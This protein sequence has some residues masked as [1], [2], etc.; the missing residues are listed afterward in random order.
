MPSYKW[1]ATGD[2]CPQDIA[3]HANCLRTDFDLVSKTS[4]I[5]LSHSATLPSSLQ[6][7]ILTGIEKGIAEARNN[8]YCPKW[9]K[10]DE[11]I[12]RDVMLKNIAAEAPPQARDR[13][14]LDHFNR[15][16]KT[17]NALHTKL[18]PQLSPTAISHQS[19]GAD[20]PTQATSV[21]GLVEPSHGTNTAAE[22]VQASGTTVTSPQDMR[23]KHVMEKKSDDGSSEEEHCKDEESEDD[24]SDDEES[25]AAESEDEE[26]KSQ[27]ANDGQAVTDSQDSQ[28]SEN[29]SDSSED[30]SND[31]SS[32]AQYCSKEAQNL[33]IT[34]HDHGT[35]F[36]ATFNIKIEHQANVILLAGTSPQMLRCKVDLSLR[37]FLQ[38]QTP[39]WPNLTGVS[40]AELQGNGD[41]KVVIDSPTRG[42]LRLFMDLA[43][44]DAEF[45]R[46]LVASPVPK[47]WLTMHN[48]KVSSSRF[49][50]RKEKAAMIKQLAD[51]NHASDERSSDNP[52]IGDVAWTND[53]PGKASA[54]LI[55]GFRDFKHANRAL[56][57]GLN[58]QRRRHRCER[59]ARDGKLIRCSRCQG[60]G[61]LHMTCS[62]SHRCGRCAGSH[63]TKTCKSEIVK[64]ASCGGPHPAGD[65][66]CRIK[67]KERRNLDFK[68]E[69]TY[70][71]TKPTAE[72]DRTPHSDVQRSTSAGRTQTEASMPSPVSLDAES[73]ED[74]VESESK[75]PLPE[76][77]TAEG[78]VESESKQPSPQA[79][80]AEDDVESEPE[81]SLPQVDSAQDTSAELATLRQEFEDIKKKFVAL[82]TILQSKVSGGTKRRADEAFVN[83]AGAESSD[84]AAKR[85]KKEE[86]TQEDS[87]GL[88]RQPSLYSE[89][90]PQ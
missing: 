75:Q 6:P 48:V 18:F 42:A 5:K 17:Y 27:D 26:R 1:P 89:D 39:S 25:E 50:N 84:M 44:W 87:M 90:R 69:N 57:N 46:T 88:Y 7:S 77:D 71:A 73:A 40:S 41:V 33:K 4:A 37:A 82:D 43:G 70:E 63:D 58:W 74:D 81:Q 9:S 22:V 36:S 10:V 78:D 56:A 11:S 30:S 3:E 55:V 28:D 53:P 45:E 85:I 62:A 72:A 16:H 35:Y 49:Q 80:T 14:P 19:V 12:F 8:G 61:H 20:S 64:C 86:P 51:V 76:V 32:G 15:L 29:D 31:S 66:G 2:D 21:G 34:N 23:D 68:D 24:E 65:K 47:Y 38:K 13:I 67:A 60:Y 83:G 59:L 54:S 52:M 79:Q